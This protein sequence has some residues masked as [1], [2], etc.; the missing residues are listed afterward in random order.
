M[1]FSVRFYFNGEELTVR[2]PR[3]ED[4]GVIPQVGDVLVSRGDEFKV[5]AR[6]FEVP[7]DPED[8]IVVVVEIE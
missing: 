4:A 5:V 8:A 2:F 6:R 1:K 3:W 7:G